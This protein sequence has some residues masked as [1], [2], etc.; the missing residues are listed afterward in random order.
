MRIAEFRSE[1]T[2]HQ[3]RL[4][5][6][7]RTDADATGELRRCK[8]RGRPPVRRPHDDEQEHGGHDDFGYE[9]GPHAVVTRGVL[10]ITVGGEA[11]RG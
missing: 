10:A 6:P 2:L 1:H 4:A 7:Y 5:A 3:L 11:S 8:A 9:A